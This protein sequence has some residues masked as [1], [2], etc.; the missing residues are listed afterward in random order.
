MSRATLS[1]F[2]LNRV[3]GCV[4]LP[5]AKVLPS[6]SG[7]I[8]DVNVIGSRLLIQRQGPKR[9][10]VGSTADYTIG[11]NTGGKAA[12]PKAPAPAK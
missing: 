3:R 8:V 2:S 1:S 9:R 4:V 6:P 7:C 11:S 10:F 5:G 12:K